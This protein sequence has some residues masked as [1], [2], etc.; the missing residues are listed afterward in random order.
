M[1]ERE[2]LHS[3]KLFTDL[4]EGLPEERLYCKEL[5]YDY[6]RTRPSE[7]DKRHQIAKKLFGKLGKNYWIE[8]PINFAY[9]SNISVGDNFYANCNLV[10]VDDTKV[11][12]GDNVLLAPNVTI[13]TTGHPIDP[14]LRQTGKMY[15][16]QVTIE[17]N[18]WIGS[19]V[20]IMPG[21]KIGKNTVIGAGSVVTKDIPS[22][23]IA[24]GNPC[25]VLRSINEQDKIYY[26]KGHRV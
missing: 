15:A 20:A 18:V 14:T 21:V 6:N 24:V 8:P 9:G 4:T 3:G 17:D 12:I 19:N 1:T 25:R 10:I 26:F 23:V 13:S 16:F 7:Q 5:I 11:V 22:N 2:K